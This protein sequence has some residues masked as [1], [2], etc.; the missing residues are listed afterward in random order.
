ME[1][2]KEGNTY[3]NYKMESHTPLSSLTNDL[4]NQWKQLMKKDR[5][6]GN[7]KVGLNKW[8]KSVQKI[9]SDENINVSEDILIMKFLPKYV[10]D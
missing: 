5:F 3:G 1:E 7:I 8:L 2:G 4:Y 10:K 9:M 6:V